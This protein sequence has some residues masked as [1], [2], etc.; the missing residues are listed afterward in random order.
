MLVSALIFF[1]VALAAA[2][3]GFGTTAM[4]SAA[5]GQFVFYGAVALL[6]LSIMGHLM[7]RV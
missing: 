1:L 2:F 7:R 6:V 3:I 4:A 5:I